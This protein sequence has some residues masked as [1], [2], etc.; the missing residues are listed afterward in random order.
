MVIKRLF[1][2]GLKAL[3]SALIESVKQLKD[4]MILTVFCLAVFALIG[5][6][7]FKGALRNKCVKTW[8]P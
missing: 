6:Q 5:L 2:T 8:P 7:L 3:V 1:S 4:V